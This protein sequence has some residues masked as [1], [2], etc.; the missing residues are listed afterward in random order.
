MKFFFCFVFCSTASHVTCFFRVLANQHLLLQPM[1]LAHLGGSGVAG[2]A[3]GA[4]ARIIK[5]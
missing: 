3:T 1:V 2:A 5:D 4:L